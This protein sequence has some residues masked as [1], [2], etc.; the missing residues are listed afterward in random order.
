MVNNIF[1]CIHNAKCITFCLHFGF[2]DIDGI[3]KHNRA[4]PGKTTSQ[5]VNKN[6]V[7]EVRCQTLFGVSEHNESDSLVGRLFQHSGDN[8]LV[9]S[10]KTRFL[11]DGLDAVED[12]FV[13]MCWG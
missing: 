12:I 2:D 10:T 5:Q 13:L 4:E 8:T 7:V 1:S 6:F 3:V 11:G 9:E